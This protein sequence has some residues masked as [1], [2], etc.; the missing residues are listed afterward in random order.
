MSKFT[1]KITTYKNAVRMKGDNIRT[2]VFLKKGKIDENF[3]EDTYHEVNIK[4]LTRETGVGPGAD[5]WITENDKLKLTRVRLSDK[6]V[7]DLYVALHHYVND[8]L[9]KNIKGEKV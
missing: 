8:V 5:C 4:S 7:I 9:M 2:S 1:P 3:Q 6:G